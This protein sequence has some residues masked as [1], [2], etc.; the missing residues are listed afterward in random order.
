MEAQGLTAL[1]WG[2]RQRGAVGHCTSVA[3][4]QCSFEKRSITA[5]GSVQYSRD[6]FMLHG[7]TPSA[8]I[9]CGHS[10]VADQ[11]SSFFAFKKINLPV[12]YC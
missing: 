8:A 1:L 3:A 9:M 12:D 6:G 4:E 7:C 11:V 5:A 2:N 10:G